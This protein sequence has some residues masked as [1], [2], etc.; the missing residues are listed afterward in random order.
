MQQMNELNEMNESL[1]HQ[2]ESSNTSDQQTI[3]LR[4][5]LSE[6]ERKNLQLQQFVQ[7]LQQQKSSLINQLSINSNSNNFLNGEL[8]LSLNNN[9][10]NNDSKSFTTNNN[11]LLME[12]KD[13][14]MKQLENQ[15]N[16]LQEELNATKNS[17][18]RNHLS[19]ESYDITSSIHVSPQQHQ[20]SNH[21]SPAS[22]TS[23]QLEQL[24]ANEK[25]FKE[26]VIYLKIFRLD[27]CLEF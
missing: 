26:K 13:S 15:V 24:R 27:Y 1:T 9:N 11:N 10:I 20:Q 5:R 14:R 22:S 8:N 16:Q 3:F 12:A 19:N 23:S 4:E 25:F 21:L 7:Q 2:L 6:E 17:I 18:N